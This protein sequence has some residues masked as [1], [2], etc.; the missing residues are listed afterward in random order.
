MQKRQGEWKT[1]HVDSVDRRKGIAF[2][3]PQGERARV[4]AHFSDIASPDDH[5]AEGDAVRFL[6]V[7]D[8]RGWRAQE[9]HRLRS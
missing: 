5:L 7:Q 3:R 9:I 6:Q 8:G 1:G 4:F 2:L